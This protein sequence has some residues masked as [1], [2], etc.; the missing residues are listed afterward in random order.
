MSTCIIIDQHACTCECLHVRTCECST[1]MYMS[2]Q[3]RRLVRPHFLGSA[4]LKLAYDIATFLVTR[5]FLDFGTLP[6]A[7]MWLKSGF[8][9]WRYIH[10]AALD[11]AAQPQPETTLLY[12]HTRHTPHTTA[13]YTHTPHTTI[14]LTITHTHTHTP[15]YY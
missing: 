14:L 7:M 9:Y 8:A 13:D 10:T 2:L 5:I 1:C 4:P 6:F 3:M 11:I 12:H 15:Q